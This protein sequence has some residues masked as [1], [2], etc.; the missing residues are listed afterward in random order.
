MCV[1]KYKQIFKMG[2]VMLIWK[3]LKKKNFQNFFSNLE[4]FDFKTEPF[5]K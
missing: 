1:K 5:F 4:N 2:G 3:L